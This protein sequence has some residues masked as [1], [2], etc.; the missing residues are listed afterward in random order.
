MPLDGQLIRVLILD[1]QIR[2]LLWMQTDMHFPGSG[3]RQCL[4]STPPMADQ[5]LKFIG[6]P[7]PA[8]VRTAEW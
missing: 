3:D 6:I 7:T 1:L 8:K 5:F 4:G 2:G